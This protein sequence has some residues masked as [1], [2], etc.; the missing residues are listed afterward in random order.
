MS[1]FIGVAIYQIGKHADW[2]WVASLLAA[3]VPVIFTLLFGIIGLVISAA[4]L[5]TIWKAAN[6]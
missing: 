2:P 6:A 1:A 5:A 4:F 3:F